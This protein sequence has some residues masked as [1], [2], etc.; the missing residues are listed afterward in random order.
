MLNEHHSTKLT[1][2]KPASVPQLCQVPQ[3]DDFVGQLE[4]VFERPAAPVEFEQTSYGRR[5]LPRGNCLQCGRPVFAVK[6]SVRF[7]PGS[8]GSIYKNALQT[9]ANNPNW[10]G[11]IAADHYHYKKLQ[12]ERY[13]ERVAA[14]KAVFDAVKSGRLVKELCACGQADVQAHHHQGYDRAN[15]LN[16][17]WRCRSCHR[18]DHGG[19]KFAAKPTPALAVKEAR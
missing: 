9:G 16:V 17:L 12:V 18:E 6:A 14:R 19:M 3:T 13:P 5:K 11:G 8:C 15:R 7:C 10:K 1:A 2:D 4:L